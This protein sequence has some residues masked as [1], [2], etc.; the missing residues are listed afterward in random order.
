MWTIRRTKGPCPEILIIIARCWSMLMTLLQVICWE[1]TATQ[2][3][4]RMRIMALLRH[5]TRQ[6]FLCRGSDSWTRDTYVLHKGKHQ[7]NKE[8]EP[9]YNQRLQSFERSSQTVHHKTDIK[10][11]LD[12][13]HSS[14]QNLHETL[15][16]S[17]G[18]A[19]SDFSD[20]HQSMTVNEG[21]RGV[22][23]EKGAC[24]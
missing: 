1:T 9:V 19:T 16:L 18:A 20:K 15:G 12:V 6:M 4:R 24:I 22:L 3:K 23:S 14:K 10:L 17:D 21:T 11:G 5:S 13:R 7:I 8:W 2:T